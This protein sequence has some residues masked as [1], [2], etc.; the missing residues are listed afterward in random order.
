LALA[1]GAI[2]FGT[3]LLYQIGPNRP[4]R[5]RNVWPGAIVATVLWFAAT[6][7]FSWYVRNIANYNVLYGSIA[8]AIA[9]LVWMYLLSVIVFTGCE[10]NVVRERVR[11]IERR[12]AK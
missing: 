5:F 7:G 10:F 11:A 9:L 4:V 2:V 8:A 1:L 6:A 3:S 12:T